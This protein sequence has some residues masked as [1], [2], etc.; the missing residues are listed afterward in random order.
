MSRFTANVAAAIVAILIATSSI[1][2]VT[3]VPATGQQL[4]VASGTMLA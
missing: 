4:A 3:T 2:A 1:T